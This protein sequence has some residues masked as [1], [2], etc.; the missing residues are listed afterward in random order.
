MDIELHLNRSQQ[1]KIEAEARADSAK[2]AKQ[3]ISD[4]DNTEKEK[5]K[6]AKESASARAKAEKELQAA[7][8]KAKKEAAA[9]FDKI[10]RMSEAEA[11]KYDAE[12]IAAEK[13][14]AQEAIRAQQQKTREAQ[15]FL[16]QEAK[17]QEKLTASQLGG[18]KSL[19]QMS[20]A[21]LGLQ[22]AAAFIGG[23][24]AE[25]GKAAAF[26]QKTAEEVLSLRGSLRDL[27]ALRGE[28]GKTGPVTGHVMSVAAQTLQTPEQVN[29]AEL[30]GRGIGELAIGKRDANG[31]LEKG[32]TITSEDFDKAL[33]SAGKLAT[34]T[35]SD[36]KALGAL[37]GQLALQA[38]H[39]LSPAEMEGQLQ[40]M[41]NIQQ[42]GGFENIGQA[43][44]Q[45]GELGGLVM[46]KILTGPEAMGTLSAFSAAGPPGQAATKTDQFIRATL[47][48]QVRA[49]GLKLD[50]D[51][52]TEKTYEYYKRLGVSK[53]TNPIKIGKAIAADLA[54]QQSKDAK[55]SPYTYLQEK[56]FG[57]VEDRNTIMSF[58]G[59]HNTGKLE[60][61]ESAQN[62]PLDM[63][64]P[65]TKQF[66][67]S[68]ANDAFF[69]DLKV[70]R[71]TELDRRVKGEKDRPYE[72]A[73]R[74]AYERMLKAGET[75]AE[76]SEFKPKG[77]LA[78]MASDTYSAFAG[79]GTYKQLNEMTRSSLEKEARR[80]NL[81]LEPRDPLSTVYST[82]DDRRLAR[83]IDAAGGDT[84]GDVTMKNLQRGA[85]DFADTMAEVKKSVIPKVPAPVQGR[86]NQ[87]ALRVP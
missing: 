43:A 1:A 73:R 62:A 29:A 17:D 57:N 42:P 41:F 36:S 30:A 39:E 63:N 20:A 37:T 16:A 40:K 3:I 7:I 12:R 21:F 75:T 69:R 72:Q 2:T 66:N 25:L 71:A 85:K 76:Y 78:E 87:P 59:L 53:E 8:T 13:K 60:K 26:A 70:E 83:R 22:S 47:G 28:V 68:V 14:V 45:Y 77:P 52:D 79:T 19:V 74:A 38:D 55:F 50:P 58:A 6:R 18:V 31:K 15:K 32:K 61:I 46:N 54:S 81:K 51:L 35:A 56:G 33:V 49:K 82:D 27:A 5:A 24:S 67:E 65:I 4:A 34:V 9:E 84:T 10:M 48:N 80:L 86:P 64:A 44:G 23:V 11:K